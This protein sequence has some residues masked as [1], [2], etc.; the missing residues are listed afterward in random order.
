[1]GFCFVTN[2]K[3]PDAVTRPENLGDQSLKTEKGRKFKAFDLYL[4]RGQQGQQTSIHTSFPTSDISTQTTTI[5][6][7]STL[8]ISLGPDQVML[9][10]NMS[11]A[12]IWKRSSTSYC[13][14]ATPM[15]KYLLTDWHFSLL[16]FKLQFRR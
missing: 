16:K 14:V 11:L 13:N 12:V 9:I 2:L 7:W 4:Q 6:R 5:N 15:Q 1:M 10:F 8:T 3:L